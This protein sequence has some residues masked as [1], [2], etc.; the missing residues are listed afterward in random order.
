M[1]LYND[2][3]GFI[4]SMWLREMRDAVLTAAGARPQDGSAQG[5]ARERCSG[6]RQRALIAGI[7]R[8]RERAFC[9]ARTSTSPERLIMATNDTVSVRA[10]EPPK[11]STPLRVTSSTFSEGGKIPMDSVHQWCGGKNNA[12]QLSWSGAPGGTKSYAITCFDP[13]APTGSGYWHWIAFNIPAS[14]TSLDAGA[15]NER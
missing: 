1:D 13:D 4:P 14:A 7:Q 5:F 9:I 10:P 11:N 3:A 12:P 2:S 15:G 8:E 6:A